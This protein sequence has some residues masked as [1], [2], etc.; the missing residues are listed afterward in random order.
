MG[1]LRFAAGAA[2]LV[3]AASA[4]AQET[5]KLGVVTFLSGPAAESFGVPAANAAKMVIE[6]F[7]TGRRPYRILFHPDGKSF[8]VSSWADGSV[9][10][11]QADNGA[12]LATTRI[13][14]HPTDMVWR[15]GAVEV[16]EGEAPIVARL[17]VAASNT[18]NVYSIGVTAGKELR[19]LESEFSPTALALMERARDLAARKESATLTVS[20]APAFARVRIDGRAEGETPLTHPKLTL[21]QHFVQVD[22]EGFVPV[23]RWVRVSEPGAQVSFELT[24]S[25]AAQL[26]QQLSLAITDGRGDEDGS[27]PR[28]G[29]E[30]SAV[31]RPVGTMPRL[32]HVRAPGLW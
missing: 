7:K 1:T 10:H 8:F 21:G 29:H 15:E 22:K 2:A 25:P 16:A 23:A 4:G 9:A 14:P 20:S 28:P 27:P 3:L 5:F 31:G 6:R 26:R 12:L 18:N 19:L 32:V 13:G 11:L 17:F 30:R 24:A